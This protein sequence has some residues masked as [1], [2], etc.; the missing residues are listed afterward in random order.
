MTEKNLLNS[1]IS[2]RKFLG[3]SLGVAAG[4][5]ILGKYALSP[6]T[7]PAADSAAAS[8]YYPPTSF[9][10]EVYTLCEMCVW[11][12]GVIAKVKDGKVVKLDGNPNHPH[13]RGMLC[14]RGQAGIATLYDPDRLKYPL[15]RKG[16][17]GE[18]KWVRAS[19][20][21]ALDYV[22]SRMLEIKDRYGPEAMIFSTTHNLI[23]TQFEN[24]LKAFGSPNYGTQRSL[25]FNAMITS[26]LLTYGM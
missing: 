6:T 14:P 1:E 11:R 25:C 15:I 13:S 12:C 9:D 8:D 18:G 10:R 4:T 22:A 2:R 21:D 16:A 19:W 7:A 3:L 5:S 17:R 20:D 23:Q 24:L 26:N